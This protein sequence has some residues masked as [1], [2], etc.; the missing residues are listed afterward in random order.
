MNKLKNEIID[1]L[2]NICS[3]SEINLSYHGDNG[4][5]TFSLLKNKTYIVTDEGLGVLDKSNN[6]IFL[7][8]EKS[9]EI[10]KKY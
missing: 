10:F 7:S 4:D 1:T 8:L 5:V 6:N 3:R 9:F 2:L